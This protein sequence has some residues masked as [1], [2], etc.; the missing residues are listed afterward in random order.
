MKEV[1]WVFGVSASG[2]ET[3][4][5][6]VI[7]ERPSD[8][9]DQFSWNGKKIAASQVSIDVI[10]SYG[11][12]DTKEKR[13]EL[14]KEVV[15]LV[16][17]NDVVLIKGQYIDY[18]AQRQVK[19]K[20]LLPDCK[21]KIVVIRVQTHDLPERLTSKPWWDKSEDPMKWTKGEQELVADL[22]KDLSQDFQVITINGNKDS[23]YEI[24]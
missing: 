9:L 4:I 2:K 12:D 1:V 18:K 14:E 7:D 16:R 5:R 6:K 15:G 3:F 17:Q 24:I 19:L 20:T 22:L 8:L 10:G 11:N 13:K 23:H 21:H